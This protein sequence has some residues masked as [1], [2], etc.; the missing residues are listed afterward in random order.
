M[1]REGRNTRWENNTSEGDGK[2]PLIELDSSKGLKVS[3]TCLNNG[4]LGQTQSR[5][6][7]YRLSHQKGTVALGAFY[8]VQ[9][10]SLSIL[11]SF[12]GRC[13]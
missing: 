2:I 4:S 9:R 5:Q 6:I 11:V 12:T 7:L 3:R 10:C 1:A 13:G 8:A